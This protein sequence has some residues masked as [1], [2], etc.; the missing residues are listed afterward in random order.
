MVINAHNT[1]NFAYVLPPE[2]PGDEHELAIPDAL[3]MGWSESPAFFYA[4]TKT[5]RDLAEE[6]L[7]TKAVQKPHPMESTAL[8]ID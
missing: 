2:H 3:Q 6:S 4:A 5:A 1:W 8:N 7:A